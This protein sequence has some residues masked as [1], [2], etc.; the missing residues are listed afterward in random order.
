M[1]GFS[2]ILFQHASQGDGFVPGQSGFRA[3]SAQVAHRG[4]TDYQ[5]QFEATL[6]L[7]HHR[8]AFQD[9][10]A[11]KQPMLSRDG[12]HIIVFNGEIY[13]HLQIRRELQRTQTIEFRT[14]SDTETI[15]EGWKVLGEELFDLLEGEYAFVIS[16][17]HGKQLVAHRDRY[18]VKPLFCYL[19]DVATRQFADYQTH[20]TFQTT[21]LEFSSEVKG[22][23]SARQWQREGLLRQFVG[24]YEPICTP[25]MHVIQI[26][27]GGRLRV[28]KTAQT[29]DCR[30]ETY[31]RAIRQ[32]VNGNVAED[33]AF[34]QVMTQSVSDRLLSD[35]ELG[36][37]L[38]GGIDSKAIAFEL[39]RTTQVGT[40]LKSFTVGFAQAGYDESQEAIRFARHLQLDPHLVRVD[41]AALNYAY[42]LAVQ[43][44]EVVQPYT[45]GAA[46]WWLSLFTRQYV[47]GVLTGDGADEVF[48]GYPSF[49]YVN[50]W[51][52]ALHIRGQARSAA[53]VAALLNKYPLGQYRRDSLYADKFASHVQNPWLAGSSAE[54]T[55]QDFIDSLAMW[56]VAHPLFGQIRTIT[57]ALLGQAA[58][59]E[60][61]RS[62]GA[63][64]RS[65]FAAGLNGIETELANPRYALL[66][67]QN[68][69]VRTHLPV[70]IL[71]W[72]GDRMEMANTL[73]GRTPFLSHRVRQFMQTQPDIAVV[74]GLR[75]KVILRRTYAR[76]F[77]AEFAMTPK[78]QFNA[79]FLD[80]AA[81]QERFAVNGIFETTGLTGNDAMHE[82]QARSQIKTLNTYEQTHL[83]S[84]LQTARSLAIVHHTLVESKSLL[85]DSALEQRYLQQGG[86][87]S[88]AA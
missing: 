21:R 32:A 77:P 4:D 85:R 20:Y 86:P 10:A 31:P 38:S 76:L 41:D 51:K 62:Q 79:P 19:A 42:P 47:Q 67:W 5:E 74:H 33:M 80:A 30:L 60:W 83:Q 28:T 65:W 81:L 59:D 39:A 23:T 71:N 44:S 25:F 43:A 82:L 6:W 70:L 88:P 75:D 8:L 48:C 57:H 3:A 87:I 46:K 12:Q 50:W 72:V 45:N 14:R 16:D 52:H 55:G 27:P 26:P 37:Y 34:E 40:R 84:A 29:L 22:L 35:V 64:I 7:S 63:S 73:E 68:Y 13:N 54:G 1:C 69:F 53:E 11:G 49:R 15:L 2:G 36:V 78:K 18:G 17:V 24:L 56:G 9:V 58:G 61:L 66:L